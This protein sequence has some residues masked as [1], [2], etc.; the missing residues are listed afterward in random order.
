MGFW[1]L[2][3]AC[4]LPFWHQGSKQN[5]SQKDWSTSAYQT[6]CDFRAYQPKAAREA[7]WAER[8]FQRLSNVHWG[9]QCSIQCTHSHLAD[10]TVHKAHYQCAI[11]MMIGYKGRTCRHILCTPISRDSSGSQVQAFPL[12]YMLLCYDSYRMVRGVPSV[13][14]T[15]ALHLIMC[16]SLGWIYRYVGRGR[17]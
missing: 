2:V 1:C 8:Q 17:A 15:S 4:L 5:G 13:N 3:L 9:S 6:C 7:G 10:R 11:R 12:R 16:E 14:L